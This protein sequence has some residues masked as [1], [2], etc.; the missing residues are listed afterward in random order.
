MTQSGSSPDLDLVFQKAL[1]AD[2]PAT[3]RFLLRGAAVIAAAA[4]IA[5]AVVVMTVSARTHQVLDAA[6]SRSE[7]L[8]STRATVLKS[9][10]NGL[11]GAGY[12]LSRSDLFRLFAAEADQAGLVA[13]ADSAL[14]S[15][16]PYMVQAVSDLARQEQFAG[17][18]VVTHD[19][20]VVLASGGAP[21][22][23][24]AQRASAVE[25]FETRQRTVSPARLSGDSLVADIL[26]PIAPPQE[27]NPTEPASVAGV[28]VMTV[29]LDAALRESLGPLPL[30]TKSEHTHLLQV[31]PGRTIILDP[32]RQPTIAP[33]GE[34]AGLV[35][36]SSLPFARRT[37]VEGKGDVFS[38]GAPVSGMPW[39]VLQE[40]DA[41]AVLAPVRSFQWTA[42]GF[43]VLA[44]LGFVLTFGAIWWR[45]ASDHA[46][47]MAGQFRQLATQ[48]NAQRRFLDS[49]M[50]TLRELVALKKPDG[51]YAYF[52]PAFARAVGR[53]DA[54]LAGMDDAALFGRGTAEKLRTSDEIA[55]R[56]HEPVIF[57]E[58]LYLPA[59]QRHFQFS[60][61]SYRDEQGK[62]AGILSV[63][64][65]ITE[66]KTAEQRRQRAIQKMT[67]ALVLTIEQVDPF[68]AGHTQN[69]GRLSAL[70]AHRLNL[71]AEKAM[72]LDIA[73]NLAQ[74]GKMAI[75]KEIVAKVGRLTDEENRIM[76]THVRHALTILKDIDF[77][78][79][80]LDTI[81]QSH[82]R[83]DGSGYPQG[84]SGDQLRLEARILAICDVFCA[85]IEERSYRSSLEPEQ[86]LV[87]L[88][89]NSNKYDAD[90][91]AE[92][93]KVLNA[94]EGEKLIAAIR[95][96]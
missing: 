10:L 58:A 74:I 88:E 44:A 87:V 5:V 91:V 23:S 39:T 34:V 18:Y 92:L 30:A 43:A 93:R 69:V 48:I 22:L 14:T 13:I 80:V 8:A 79:P 94:V 77:D 70:L 27:P 17:T 78:L 61:V 33:I 24:E 82:E 53:T 7:I 75:P 11:G 54:Q 96:R 21:E 41:S 28:L 38:S 71:P 26:L 16:V 86:A 6:K 95:R 40:D 60:K 73:A 62:V 85:R 57:E 72:T 2:K 20:R 84:L 32:F 64:R 46:R 67:E 66:Q 76:Q 3:S 90:I 4:V 63:A 37:A 35:Q 81:A 59:G 9:W 1:D 56:E 52:N 68:L 65:D 19:G 45:Q 31:E 49:L 15:Q 12:R 29:P 47:A 51:N 25:V 42:I 89:Q 36:E 55:L 50:S 83:L